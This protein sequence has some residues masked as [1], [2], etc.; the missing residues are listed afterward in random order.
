MCNGSNGVWVTN[1]NYFEDCQSA[2]SYVTAVL[3]SN[4]FKWYG[5][6]IISNCTGEWD[7]DAYGDL[8]YQNS[9][10]VYSQGTSAGYVY[11]DSSTTY[12]FN[13][14]AIDEDGNYWWY[15]G[16]D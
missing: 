8:Y 2:P 4:H 3:V 11:S 16:V 1:H 6:G 5:G 10:F 12:P 14:Y 7:V 9:E 13:S 15:A